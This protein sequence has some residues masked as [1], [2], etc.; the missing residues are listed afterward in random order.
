MPNDIFE[1][2]VN[3]SANDTLDFYL[4][5]NPFHHFFTVFYIPIVIVVGLIGNALSC[6]VLLTT[7]LK[8]RSSSYYLA[9]LSVSDFVFLLTLLAPYW[10]YN[11]IINI[12]N[13]E[14]FCQ[15][16]IYLGAVTSF[17]SVWLIVAF[18]TERF[19]A[20]RYPLRRQYMCT[21]SRAQM[22]IAGITVAGLVSQVPMLWM[23]KVLIDNDDKPLCEMEPTI[24][25]LLA[26]FL[27]W[28]DT[29]LTFVIPLTS[30]LIMNSMIGKILFNS[31][32]L[33]ATDDERIK[34]HHASSQSSD[35]TRLSDFDSTA[36]RKHVKFEDYPIRCNRHPR[37]SQNQSQQNINTMLFIISSVFIILNFPR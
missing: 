37:S 25:W 36:S 9:A 31:R 20:V 19:I 7:H 22:I 11:D 27:N 28:L 26:N 35:S 8:M 30:L 29:I 33:A 32:R 34:F 4:S 14:G 16:F 1:L 12:F 10:S 2:A 18:T 21:V 15:F 13:Q 6:F 24:N 23:A 3:V 5:C 17:I